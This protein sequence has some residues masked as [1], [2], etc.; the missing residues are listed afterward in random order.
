MNLELL[1]VDPSDPSIC[2]WLYE[3]MHKNTVEED[4]ITLPVLASDLDK[5]GLEFF[6][7]MGTDDPPKIGIVSFQYI[8]PW[9]VDLQ[10]TMVDVAHRGKGYG[11]EISRLIEQEI[12]DRGHGKIMMTCYSTNM[13]IINLKLSEGYLIEGCLRDHYDKGKHDFIFGKV[14]R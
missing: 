3:F 14:L 2:T 5:Q 11:R 8:T 12:R 6:I 9:L 10:R 13:A 4:T 1:H 7:A